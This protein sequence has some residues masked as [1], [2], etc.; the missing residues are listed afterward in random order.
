VIQ[1]GARAV[2]LDRDGVLNQALIS[3]GKPGAPRTVD[4]FVI[5]PDRAACLEELKRRGFALIVVTNQPDVARGRQSI[6]VIEEMHRRLQAALPVDDVLVCFHDE[7][8]NCQ[9]RKPRPGLLIEAQRKYDLDLSRSFLIGDRWKDVDAGN[10]AGCRTVFIDYNYSERGPSTEPSVRVSSLR[11]AVDWISSRGMNKEELLPH[12][13]SDFKVK[14]FADGA[15][16]A[17]M[18]E[19]YRNP[20]IKGF[21]T[22][23]TLMRAAGIRD[24][25]AFALDILSSISDRPISFEVFADDPDE[26]YQQ[27]LEI[28]GWGENVYVKIPITNTKGESALGVARE[29]SRG[30]VKLNITALLALDQ[31]RDTANALDGG[32]PACVSVFAGRI[33]DTGR[34]PVPVMKAAAELVHQHPGMELIWASP[35]ELFNLIQADSIDCDII[36]A[37]PDVLKKLSLL[38]KDLL[39]YSRETVQMYYDDARKSGF[40]LTGKARSQVAVGPVRGVK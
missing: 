36:T 38:G 4:E 15:D 9:C 21:T 22:N 34:D 24:Y 31:V 2:F 26:M 17:A 19:L 3:G 29:L 5:P 35:R 37:I 23:P 12:S 16:K 20:W 39:E 1:P 18:L 11:D 28:A 10:A 25:E 14:L 40:T 32:A 6:A 13:V 30:G 8:D 27:A 33:A 7:A